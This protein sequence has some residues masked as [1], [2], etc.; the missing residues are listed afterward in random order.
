[1]TD[2]PP[3]LESHIQADIRL[4]LGKLRHT[5]LFRNSKGQGWMG[6]VVR[7]T[8]K[9][10]VLSH[11]RAVPFGILAPGSS[12]LIGAVQVVITPDMVGQTI[13][14]FTALEVKRP[15]VSVPVEQQGFVTFVRDFGGR[16]DIV[17][18]VDDAVRVVS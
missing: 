10:V 6:T 5:R 17:R 11:P 12:D 13:A 15:G 1:M 9:E 4:A 16:A 2:E 14:V 3:P 8:Q 18:S 7:R